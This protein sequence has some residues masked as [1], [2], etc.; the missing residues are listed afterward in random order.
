MKMRFPSV[1][2]L[3]LFVAFA[4]PANAAGLIPKQFRGAWA[5]EGADCSKAAVDSDQGLVIDAEGYTQ[6]EQHCSLVKVAAASQNDLN[7]QWECQEEGET[8]RQSIRLSL[9]KAGKRLTIDDRILHY[10]GEH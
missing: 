8:Y 1:A 2:L 10:C 6:L 9:S 7:G 3:A 5:D 4:C